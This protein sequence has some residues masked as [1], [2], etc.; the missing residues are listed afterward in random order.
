MR[1]RKVSYRAVRK[2]S[3]CRLINNHVT[4]RMRSDPRPGGREVL[5][6]Y[7]IRD[8]GSCID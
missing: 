4:P 6:L 2:R 8:T 1:E 3:L 7:N 5:T